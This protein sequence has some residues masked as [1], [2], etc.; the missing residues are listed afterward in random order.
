M[1]R[2][3]FRFQKKEFLMGGAKLTKKVT[4]AA[5]RFRLGRGL[6]SLKHFYIFCAVFAQVSAVPCF[7]GT[8]GMKAVIDQLLTRGVVADK[9]YGYFAWGDLPV[10]QQDVSCTS[11]YDEIGMPLTGVCKATA[12]LPDIG[13][14]RAISATYSFKLAALETIAVELEIPA[15]M[16]A[17]GELPDSVA[18]IKGPVEIHFKVQAD[19]TLATLTLIHSDPQGKKKVVA[20]AKKASEGIL[21]DL[22]RNQV[23]RKSPRVR[24]PISP[25]TYKRASF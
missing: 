1:E 4:E 19:K 21:G 2:P 23:W 6:L 13:T 15:D 17:G 11:K 8:P 3:L 18:L 16:L 22:T 5:A 7:A 14:F 10:G 9:G 25:P 12:G 20:D 24:I